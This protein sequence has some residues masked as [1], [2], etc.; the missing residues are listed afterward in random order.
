MYHAVNQ[1][2]ICCLRFQQPMTKSTV[3]VCL[4]LP[5]KTSAFGTLSLDK[6]TKQTKHLLRRVVKYQRYRSISFGFQYG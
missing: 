2:K 5:F 1:H 3:M 6:K 4:C